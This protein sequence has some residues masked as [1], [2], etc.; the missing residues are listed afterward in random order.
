MKKYPSIGTKIDYETEVIGFDKLDGS[1]IRAFWKAADRQFVEFGTR[2]LRLQPD[3][4]YLG[5]AIEL[6]KER[7]E[8]A[9]TEIF[10]EKGYKEVTAFFEF[11]GDSS[12]AGRHELEEEKHVVLIDLMIYKKGLIHPVEF[13]QDYAHLEIPQVL[14]QGKLDETTVSQIKEGTLP[15]MSLEG[16]VFKGRGGKKGGH[17]VTF[18]VKS[19]AWIENL[20]ALCAGDEA[21]F[22]KML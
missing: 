20:R 22:A 18:K 16:V 13:I 7:H 19:R 2:T 17:P 6:I 1:N 12:F 3:H 21:L 11:F 9:L 5:R 4:R 10:L 15:N 14:F 8:T